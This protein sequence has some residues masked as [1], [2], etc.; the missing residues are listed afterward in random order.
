MSLLKMPHIAV[1][2]G[3]AQV[4]IFARFV[5]TTKASPIYVVMIQIKETGEWLRESK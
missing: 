2:A 1:S 5:G 3:L 4:A